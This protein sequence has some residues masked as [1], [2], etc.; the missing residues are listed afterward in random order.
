MTTYT[1]TARNDFDHIEV[2]LTKVSPASD[3]I[4]ILGQGFNHYTVIDETT[5]EVMADVYF[6]MEWFDPTALNPADCIKAI[7]G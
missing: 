1:I 3:L 4:D 6:H 2:T 5:G 7:I